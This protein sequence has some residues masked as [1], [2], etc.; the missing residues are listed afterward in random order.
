M[1]VNIL[2][3]TFRS[4]GLRVGWDLLMNCHGAV[5]DDSHWVMLGSVADGV[6]LSQF[7]ILR[8]A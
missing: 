2:K 1:K 8:E 3:K 6:F 4:R 7:P 5:V